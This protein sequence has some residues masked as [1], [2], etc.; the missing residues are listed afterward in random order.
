MKTLS[1][2]DILK[3]RAKGK[4]ILGAD[5][6]KIGPPPKPQE[7]KKVRGSSWI[8]TFLNDITA[9]LVAANT[10]RKSMNALLTGILSKISDGLSAKE[11]KSE[12]IGSKKWKFT[13]IRDREGRIKE[14]E[15]KA[16]N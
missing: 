6:A 16:L 4:K 8:K 1:E 15:A 3:L 5:G 2:K 12:E 10:E 11:Q 7:V 14:I 13:V 9:S